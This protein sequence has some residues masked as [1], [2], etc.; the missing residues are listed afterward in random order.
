MAL[1]LSNHLQQ[2]R[3]LDH[4][5]SIAVSESACLGCDVPT[6]HDDGR[7]HSLGPLHA[8]KLTHRPDPDLSRLPL[9]G[10]NECPAPRFLQDQI[11]PTIRPRP[12][13]GNAV[14]LPPKAFSKQM[15]ELTP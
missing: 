5:H 7:I 6:R 1:H 9:L 4:L 11:D 8:E 15:F 2:R 13:V 3:T 14:A 10:L 12:G